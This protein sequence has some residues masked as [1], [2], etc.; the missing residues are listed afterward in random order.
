MK[1]N[2]KTSL[3]F[4]CAV[5]LILMYHY[6]VHNGLEKLFSQT[7]FNYHDVKRPSSICNK[8]F[9]YSR[10]SC[11]GMPSG[12]A[13]T[14]SVLCFILYFYKIIPLWLC[15]VVI[16][17]VSL[18]RIT[19]N[20]HTVSQVLI[21]A[22]LGLLYATIYKKFNLSIYSFIVVFFIGFL[23]T[24][25]NI[26]KIDRNINGPIPSWVDKKML[27]LI[28]K[29]QDVPFYIKIGSLYTNAIIQNRTFISWSQLEGYLDHIVER[30]K[31][32]GKTYD[33][34]VGIKTGGAIISDY[35]SQKLGLPNYK[36]KLSRKEYNCDK[37]YNDVVN[38]LIQKNI[39]ENLG[40]YSICEGINAN[41]E[42]KN[43]I[44]V[45]E[46]VSTGKT[47]EEAYSYLKENKFV[48]NVYTTAVSFYEDK[49]K[50]SLHINH[51]LNGTVII[52]PWGYDN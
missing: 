12:H 40:D 20:V 39:V 7:Y 46:L 48:N 14:S 24:L 16:F 23:I 50:G 18:Q 3:Y 9:N 1:L 41:L 21:G 37:K 10:L 28:K 42:G 2:N 26:Y 33:A 44:L 19:S 36:I 25:I 34:V 38:D 29:K 27:P 22:L 17:V 30:I 4:I 52:W 5:F 47:M 8:S 13:E 45:D 35:I 15:L 51:I 11:V 31:K 32:S 43:I 49:Y 6:H